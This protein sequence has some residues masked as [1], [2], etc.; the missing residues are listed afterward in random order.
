MRLSVTYTHCASSSWEQTDVI[1]T[2]TQFEEGDSP[3]ETNS[4]PETRNDAKSG[5]ESDDNSI[6]PPL[7]SKEEI[8]EM[9]YGNES[10]HDHI[11]TEMLEDICDGSQSH[12]SVNIIEEC[13]KICDRI[14]QRQSK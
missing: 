12:H 6:M 11:S 9:D 14:K 10:Y 8:D 13:Y 4:P 1:I 3:S 7:L 5:D 2:F